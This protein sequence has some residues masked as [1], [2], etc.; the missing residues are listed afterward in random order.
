[1]L[2]AHVF[3]ASIVE[4]LIA[5]LGVAYFQKRQPEY[6]TSL[7]AVFAPTRASD[8]QASPRPLWQLVAGI[9]VACVV[10]F[11]VVGLAWA[12]GTRLSCSAPTGARWTGRRWHRCCSSRRSSSSILV[13]LAY[14]ILPRACKRVG[15]AFTAIAVVAPIGL[16]APGFAYGEGSAEDVQAAFG[17]VP[18]GLQDLSGFFSAPL[19]DYNI[20]LPFFSGANA[21]LWHTAHRLRDRR[22]P[23]HAPVRRRGDARHPSPRHPQVHARRRRTGDVT[24]PTP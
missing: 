9:V 13:P 8:G 20:P 2:I 10:A 11:A 15:T 18:Q 16:I 14:F 21:A 1:M 22:D 17:Y 23:R 3:G 5:G 24:R 7:K 6:L 4:G 12:A 19:A